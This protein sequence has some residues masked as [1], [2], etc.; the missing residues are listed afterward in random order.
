MY[1]TPTPP[2][3]CRP[4]PP[5]HPSHSSPQASPWHAAS[6][7]HT[8]TGPPPAAGGVLDVWA[9][10]QS[11]L[12]PSPP[13][14]LL[15]SQLSSLAARLSIAS[16]VNDSIGGAMEGGLA[17]PPPSASISIL[18][19]PRHPRDMG[20]RA[21]GSCPPRLQ[22]QRQRGRDGGH[23]SPVATPRKIFLLLLHPPRRLN[24]DLFVVNFHMQY[25]RTRPLC[26]HP[27]IADALT[28]VSASAIL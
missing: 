19:D 10:L 2:P 15:S 4:P 23:L 24:W 8:A 18:P 13:C 6:I 5:S 22:S 1:D 11:L 28:A 21:W 12:S 20:R 26:L 27:P 14:W 3:S 9:S 17:M 25:V 16:L 7:W